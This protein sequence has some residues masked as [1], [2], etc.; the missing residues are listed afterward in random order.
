MFVV[1]LAYLAL[2]L[3]GRDVTASDVK[4]KLAGITARMEV[5]QARIKV[6]S[7]TLFPL[8]DKRLKMNRIELPDNI[9][10]CIIGHLEIVSAEFR[11]YFN[12]ETLHVSWRTDP[13]NTEIDPIAEETEELA[14]FKVSNAIKLAKFSNAIS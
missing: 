9:K 11:S 2:S 1:V 10:T 13:F 7:T 12:D 5:W 8:L 14:K 3:Q 6:G 4:D